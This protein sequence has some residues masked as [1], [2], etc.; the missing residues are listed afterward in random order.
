[1]YSLQCLN[2]SSTS[3]TATVLDD[4]DLG[5]DSHGLEHEGAR[6]DDGC[7]QVDQQSHR[8][9]PGQARHGAGQEGGGEGDGEGQEEDHRHKR[10]QR[11]GT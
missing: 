10:R 5:L 1:M 4:L 9:L 8:E 6:D 11:P 7:R 3:V 2:N